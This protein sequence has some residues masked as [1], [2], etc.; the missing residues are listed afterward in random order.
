MW[1]GELHTELSQLLRRD[2]ALQ[3]MWAQ[4]PLCRLPAACNAGQPATSW[5]SWGTAALRFAQACAA[6]RSTD[7]YTEPNSASLGALC[8]QAC[9]ARVTDALMNYETVKYFTND[10]YEGL[11]YQKAIKEYQ[12]AEYR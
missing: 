11:Q 4:A 3:H 12:T 5:A 10:S 8:V 1:G 2:V 6:A 7:G 9:A